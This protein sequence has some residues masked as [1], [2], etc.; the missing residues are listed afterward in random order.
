MTN[1]KWHENQENWLNG[2]WHT[3]NAPDM[4]N[5]FESNMKVVNQVFRYFR[6]RE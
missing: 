2:D 4:E 1:F 6:E 5:E 3:L